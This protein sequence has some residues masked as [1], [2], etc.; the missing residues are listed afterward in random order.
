[1][2]E[3]TEQLQASRLAQQPKELAERLNQLGAGQ[4]QSSGRGYGIAI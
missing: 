4:A 2:L 3:L 1:M